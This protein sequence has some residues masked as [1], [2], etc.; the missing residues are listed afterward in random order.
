[1]KDYTHFIL[2][3]NGSDLQST[4]VPHDSVCIIPFTCVS[5]GHCFELSVNI[6]G[7]P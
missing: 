7:V 1:M 3:K 5:V 6:D 4:S 2:Q